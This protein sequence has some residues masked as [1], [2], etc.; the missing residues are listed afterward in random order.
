MTTL[1]NAENT[2]LTTTFKELHEWEACKP[3]YKKL[4]KKLGGIK[5]YGQNTPIK[6]SQILD[7]CGLDD[8]F[9]VLE[10]ATLNKNYTREIRLLGCDRAERVLPIFESEHPEDLRPRHAIETARRYAIGDASKEELRAAGWDANRAAGAV[11]VAAWV[12]TRAAWAAGDAEGALRAAWAA[13]WDPL[14]AA[15]AVRAARTAAGAAVWDTAWA[16]AEAAGD[17]ARAAAWDAEYT[18]QTQMLRDVLL[19]LECTPSKE[20]KK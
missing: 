14:A 13:D 17:A 5:T 20:D 10:R 4:A 8:C 16:A 12:A 7:I 18:A 9:W 11:R 19:K 15:G 2:G 1:L 6:L 3:S